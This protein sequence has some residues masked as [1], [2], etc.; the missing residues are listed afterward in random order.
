M[1]K[2]VYSIVLDDEIINGIDML[3][4]REGTSRSNL[5]NRL[6]A[7][8]VNVPTA[9]TIIGDIFSSMEQFMSGHK[10]LALQMLQ[11]NSLI[12]MKTALQYRYNPSIK[13]TVELFEN[14]DYFGQLK[15]TM[16]SQN[17]ALIA[18]LSSFF[19]DWAQLEIKYAGVT[20]NELEAANG[21]FTRLIRPVRYTDYNKLG[22][23]IAG[24]IDLMDRCMKEYFDNYSTS[25][26]LAQ[27][28]MDNTY[29][30]FITRDIIEI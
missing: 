30:R 28:I 4:A 10:S 15:V 12:N 14:S 26:A 13:Y 17:P 5:I 24:Y 9:E 16:R 7:Q 25:P 21:R 8:H 22:E 6:L 1:G 19:Y 11:S 27:K 23:T 29:Q 2:S 20:E 3:A 18:I